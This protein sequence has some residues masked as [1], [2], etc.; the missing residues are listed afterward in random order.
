MDRGAGPS[1]TCARDRLRALCIS[2]GLVVAPSAISWSVKHLVPVLQQYYATKPAS[3]F[4]KM[5][6]KHGGG[7]GVSRVVG[8]AR[9][10]R[11][12]CHKRYQGD[13]D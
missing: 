9:R 12:R 13:E 3:T 2:T 1:G 7:N 5:G 11:D 10:V 4:M 6:P 8:A